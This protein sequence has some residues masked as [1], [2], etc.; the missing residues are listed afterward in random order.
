MTYKFEKFTKEET[1]KHLKE[2]RE[3]I[4]HYLATTNGDDINHFNRKSCLWEVLTKVL[5]ELESI[6]TIR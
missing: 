2:E 3:V 4:D 5:K 6:K 1:I